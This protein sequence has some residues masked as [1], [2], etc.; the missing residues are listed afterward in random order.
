VST[1]ESPKIRIAGNSGCVLAFADA[2][3]D[4]RSVV[5]MK[6]VKLMVLEVHIIFLFLFLWN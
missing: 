2:L 5:V 1:V 6:R 4:P 3:Q